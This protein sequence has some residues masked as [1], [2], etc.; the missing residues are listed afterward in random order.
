MDQVKII[1]A[2][3]QQDTLANILSVSVSNG[4]SPYNVLKDLALL[5]ADF[6]LEG[7]GLLGDDGFANFILDDCK[8]FGIDTAQLK[9]KPGEV[10]SITDVMTVADT[11]RRTFFHARGANSVLSEADLD[12]E[13]SN[14]KI[15]HI[16]YLLL[17]TALDKLDNF[18]NTGASG[19]LKKATEL[20]FKTSVDIVS[21]SSERFGSV[22]KPSLPFT[23]YLFVNEFEAGRITGNEL[24]ENGIVSIPKAKQA[25]RDL[26]DFGVREWVL[27]HFPQGALAS[28]KDGSIVFQPSL[29][30]PEDK[31]LGAAGAGDAFA[32]GVLMGLH[33]NERILKSLK[34]GVCA[35]GSSLF[36]PS[37]SDGVM[38]ADKVLDLEKQ[39]GFQSYL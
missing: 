10:T 14:A 23:D 37:C 19:I 2:Y 21:E 15:F 32:A 11:G 20:G 22:V 28:H 8:R 38:P 17:L 25:S 24:V 13:N 36:H 18:G 39:F 16:G 3:P 1:D 12:L 33:N 31:I 30:L 6:P 27:L 35:A 26:L 5:G 7:A 4:G 9:Q 29:S 34:L